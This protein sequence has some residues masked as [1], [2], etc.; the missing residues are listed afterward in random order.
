VIAPLHPD[1]RKQL[2]KALLAARRVG[3]EGARAAL[4]ALAVDAARPHESMSAEERGLR[5]RIR[6]HGRQLGD[7]RDRQSGVQ[8]IG[9]LAHEVACEHW[10][11]MLFARFLAETGLLVEPRS[12]VS[13]SLDECAELARETGATNLHGPTTVESTGRTPRRTS[14]GSGSGVGVVS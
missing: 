3:E 9:R 6:A 7:A 8:E 2:Q 1:L 4:R 12:R 14:R 10:H 11:R 5:L 13:V